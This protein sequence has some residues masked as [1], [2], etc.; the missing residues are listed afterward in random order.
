MAATV[1]V[2]IAQGIRRGCDDGAIASVT[3]EK[4]TMVIHTNDS[5]DQNKTSFNNFIQPQVLGTHGK[6]MPDTF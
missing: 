6:L 2:R 1:T 5:G 3:A 4:T